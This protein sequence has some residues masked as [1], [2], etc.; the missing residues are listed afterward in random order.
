MEEPESLRRSQRTRRPRERYG[1]SPETI[2]RRRATT[3]NAAQ[4][5]QHPVPGGAVEDEEV[6]QVPGGL[7]SQDDPLP[8]DTEAPPGHTLTWQEEGLP[9]WEEAHSS[10]IPTMKHIPKAAREDWA[11]ILGATVGDVCADP[12]NSKRWLLLYILPRCVLRAM[13]KEVASSGRSAAQVVREAC[14]RWRSGEAASLWKEAVKGQRAPPKKGR[15]KAGNVDPL[16]QEKR[17]ARRASALIQEGQLSRAA[18]A[19]VSR[20]MDQ[21]SAASRKEMEE[22]HP[23]AEVPSAPEEAPSEPPFTCSSRQVYEAVRSFKAGTAAGPSG[24]RA[25]HL[26]EAKGRGEGRGAAALGAITR[27]VNCMAAGKV[28]EE[29]APFLF[30]ANL[31]AVIKKSGGFRP[32][33]VGDVLRRLTS[34]V[35]MCEVAGPAAQMLRPLQFGVGVRGG[36]EAVVHATRATLNS[37]VLQPEQKWCL[38]VDFENGF[39]NIDREHMFGEVRRRFPHLSPWVES[40]YGQASVLN[41]GST[42]IRS[43]AGVQ[44]GDPLGPLLFSLT[45]QPLVEKLQEVAGLVQNSWYLDDGILVGTPDALVQAWDIIS[46]EGAKRGLFLS[47]EKSLVYNAVLEPANKDPLSRGVPRADLKGFKLLGAPLGTEEYEGEI[48]EERLISIR[49]LLDSLHLLDDPHMEFQLLKSCLSFPKVAFSLRTVDTSRHQ[50]FRQKFDWAVRETLEGILGTP[51]TSPQWQQASLPVASGG[52]GLRLADTHG[53]AAFLS[54]FGAS[55]LL[56]QEMR[57]RQQDFNGTNVDSA[58]E[59]LNTLLGDH[60]TQGEVTVMTQRKLSALVDEESHSRLLQ[61]TAVPRELARLNCVSREGAGDWL[62]ALPSKTLGLHLRRTEF[63]TAIRYRLGLP[64]FRVQGE[65]P[66]PAC[67]VTNDIMGDHAISCAIG[68]ERISKH[69]HV[70]DAIFKAAVEAGLGPVREPDGLLPGSDDRPADVLIPIWTEGRDTA[71]DI[72][73]VNPLQQALLARASEEGDSAVEHA[74]KAKLRKYEE[75]C[76]AEAITFLPLAVDTF[77]GWH[78]VGLATITKLGKQLARNLGKEEDEV[79]RHLRQR[80]GVLIVRD[81][82]MMMASRHPTFAPPD[83]DGD[84]GD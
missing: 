80:L 21:S 83:V 13:P 19:L 81:N 52:L 12:S 68:G 51:L 30:G 72:T 62:N 84:E 71:L 35:I 26:K 2:E 75:R 38:Q 37:D 36:C 77:G 66:M 82:A 49:H 70:R 69:N 50:Q 57:W 24:L 56:V 48:L 58:L 55:Q 23:Q 76:D 34:K 7:Q 60:L 9:G 3:T 1:F 40:C 41:F 5:E 31:F 15:K 27:L 45:E 25:E 54:S 74:H 44:Q 17:N 39:N 14:R 73:V 8:G 63:I 16:S 43:S 79:V 42:T 65:C 29:V 10:A 53:A 18:K 28:S 6:G 4:V 46:S 22:K 32:V 33:A 61:A 59:E 47:K 20:G 67:H 64:V 11:R 78:K